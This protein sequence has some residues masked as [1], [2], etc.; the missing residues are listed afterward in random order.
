MIDPHKEKYFPLYW[1]IANQ[2]AKESTAKRK[3]VGAVIVAP[4]GMISIGWNGLPSGFKGEMEYRHPVTQELTTRPEVIH[5]ERNAIDKMTRQGI[6]IDGSILFCTYTP[7]IEC[8][9]SIQGLG[10]KHVY[11]REASRHPEGPAFLEE[12]GIPLTKWAPHPQQYKELFA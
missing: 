3:K 11:F 2:A 12:A 5:A 7:C 1:R 4:T 8:A 9:K 10:F 6:P